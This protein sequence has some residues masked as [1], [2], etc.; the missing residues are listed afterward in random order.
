MNI[1]KFLDEEQINGF[2]YEG[3]TDKCTTHSYGLDLYPKILQPFSNQECKILELG[4]NTGGWAYTLVKMLP[5]S[6]VTTID[7]R[8]VVSPLI[9]SR[10]TKEERARFT[11]LNFDAYTQSALDHFGKERFDVIFEDG[12]HTLPSQ[13]FA[14]TRYCDLLTPNGVLVIEDIQ[15]DQCMSEILSKIPPEN[16]SNFVYE[17]KDL[18]PAIGRYD[19]LVLIVR[20]KS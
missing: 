18:R 4:T 6:I 3:G 16:S 14:A 15:N 17:V 19:D 20:R 10:L 5:K 1:R 8:N 13:I 9:M 11:F 7:I 12:P 2:Q